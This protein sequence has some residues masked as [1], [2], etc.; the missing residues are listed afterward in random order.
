M[1]KGK[2]LIID[3]NQELLLALKLFL[4]PHFAEVKTQKKSKFVTINYRKR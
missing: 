1:K 4:S 3:D 2:I